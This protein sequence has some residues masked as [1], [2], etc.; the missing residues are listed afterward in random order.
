VFLPLVGEVYT[1]V[2]VCGKS[3]MA[4][5]LACL[6]QI[7]AAKTL[8]RSAK[9]SALDYATTSV[10]P[11]STRILMAKRS[12]RIEIQEKLCKRR[13]EAWKHF[14][15][16]LPVAGHILGIAQCAGG[17]YQ[18]GSETIINASRI[19]VFWWIAFFASRGSVMWSGNFLVFSAFIVDGIISNTCRHVPWLSEKR[20]PFGVFREM[21]N[22]GMGWPFV[23]SIVSIY[24]FKFSIGAFLSFLRLHQAQVV[25][26]FPLPQSAPAATPSSV[27]SPAILEM[28]TGRK[29]RFSWS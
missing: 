4:G 24:L 19:A 16:D 26:T 8:L 20:I 13:S 1:V 15:Q 6:C 7:R 25:T 14:I 9:E 2:D 27:P 23:Y 18:L 10:F 5:F 22:A 11:S 21:D 3:L 12:N 17:D 28:I 29:D